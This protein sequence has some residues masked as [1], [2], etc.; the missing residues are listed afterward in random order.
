MSRT[1]PTTA[2]SP[3]LRKLGLR[4]RQRGGVME[5]DVVV[6][7]RYED[8][9]CVETYVVP[10]TAHAKKVIAEHV[11]EIVSATAAT[12]FPFEWGKVPGPNGRPV[13]GLVCRVAVERIRQ[14]PRSTP[15]AYNARTGAPADEQLP[16]G[17][18][19]KTFNILGPVW[20]AGMERAEN[21]DSLSLSHV[22]EQLLALYG[23]GE[24]AFDADG[25]IIPSRP[26]VEIA[27]VVLL[28][29]VRDY[30]T[31]T[32]TGMDVNPEGLAEALA[33]TLQNAG[34][35]RAV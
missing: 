8:D 32:G 35:A 27:R 34:Y 19:R 26:T 17:K 15:K 6:E 23:D 4:Q 1:T 31:D 3:I 28:E 29:A 21:V 25:Q 13:A 33:A 10:Q 7:G 11:E 30:L 20:K 18:A 16:E 9:L 5:V 24:F 22:T 14:A 2:V 12:P